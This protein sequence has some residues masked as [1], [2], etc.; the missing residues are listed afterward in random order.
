[1]IP[2]FKGTVSQQEMADISGRDKSSVLRSITSLTSKNFVITAQDPFDK[3][4]K[5][6][7][8]TKDGKTL[9]EKIAHE[10]IKLDELV[11]SCLS[12][13][14]RTVFERLLQKCEKYVSG[15]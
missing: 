4:K 3:R 2:Y 5:M 13:E 10:I 8:L 15:L 14:E 1:M 9:A 12:A 11:F 6:V 7:Q